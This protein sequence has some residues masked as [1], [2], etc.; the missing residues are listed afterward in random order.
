LKHLKLKHSQERRIQAGSLWIFSNQVED[1]VKEFQPGEIVRVTLH[2]GRFLGIGYVNP[3]SL[4]SVRIL[5]TEERDIEADFFQQRFQQAKALR[6]KVLPGEAAVREVF[7]ESDGLPGLIVDRYGDIL[8]V[9]ITTA[10]M[11]R[12]REVIV[13]VLAEVYTPRGIFERSDSGVRK[14]EDLEPR[15]GVLWGEIPEE[16]VW[17]RYAG[18]NMPV[19]VRL[20]QKT[21]L[22]LDQR[23]NLDLIAGLASG[24][25]VLD[26]FCYLGAWGIKAAKSGAE[27]VFF[28]DSS[29]WALD[30][31]RATA[32]RNR[33]GYLCELIH[34]EA[35]DTF[36]K[37]RAQ[38]ESFD[39]V[40]LDPPS[41]IKSRAR[42]KEG[43]KG[44]YNL[45]QRALELL[46]PGGFLVTCSCSHHMEEAAFAEMARSVMHRAGR[47]GRLLYKGRQ[48][49][50]HPVLPQMPETEYL[51]CL[52]Y[53]IT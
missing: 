40:I 26:A 13:P 14:L 4:I 38:G 23:K 22:Y 10:G 50:D 30:Q 3:H 33:V 2:N 42:Y 52:V 39:L 15:V 9:Q 49:P 28:L 6:A 21:G 41:F 1:S 25:R 5:T 11:D 37:L 7:S 48:G 17:V 20:G 53:Q 35:F 19:D 8:V 29:E 18:L 36:K 12:L 32:S 43:Y 27:E 46:R 51:H 47:S 34:G 31:I 24:A 16:P 44:Y 45:N